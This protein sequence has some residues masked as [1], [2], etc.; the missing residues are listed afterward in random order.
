M[1]TRG[2]AAS[3]RSLAETQLRSG[4]VAEQMGA[5]AIAARTKAWCA[6]MLRARG[7]PRDCERADELARAAKEEVER[8]GLALSVSGDTDAER[9]AR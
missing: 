3:W 5:R 9:P 1:Q 7:G 6:E 4:A 8:M 2:S